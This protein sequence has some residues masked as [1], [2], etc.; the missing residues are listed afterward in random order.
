MFEITLVRDKWLFTRKSKQSFSSYP[1]D[2][3]K[4]TTRFYLSLYN[5]VIK[6]EE[7]MSWQ[8]L[9]G[10]WLSQS[11]CWLP[12][13]LW[14]W[15]NQGHNGAKIGGGG[16]GGG[17]Y[18]ITTVCQPGHWLNLAQPFDVFSV[19]GSNIIARKPYQGNHW[20]RQNLLAL[21]VWLEKN[22]LPCIRCVIGLWSWRSVGILKK[23]IVFVASGD[24]QNC[25]RFWWAFNCQFKSSSVPTGHWY[26]RV[27]ILDAIYTV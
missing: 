4:V 5:A 14:S 13:C 22:R 26:S 24:G 27:Q 15:Y 2:K 16:G 8:C 11:Y 17:Y 3:W 18:V 23:T 12:K 21:Q 6:L 19:L 20:L 7:F 1:S 10:Q 9:H 25:H